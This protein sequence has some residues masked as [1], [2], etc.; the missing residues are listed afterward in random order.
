VGAC[1]LVSIAGAVS[2]AAI[3]AT[4]IQQAGIGSEEIRRPA[5]AFDAADT[6]YRTE[7]LPDHYAM[8]TPQGRVEV[9]ELS[10]RGLYAQDRF[11]YREAAYEA[12]AYSADDAAYAPEPSSTAEVDAP[13]VETAPVHV[14]VTA[15]PALALA[16]PATLTDVADGQ[17]RI[18]D[19]AATLAAR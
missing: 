4:P 6:G 13:A 5:A 10:T 14:A 1:A 17:P 19:V 11:G 8:I 12:P 9:A 3:N 15:Q 16:Q 18:I 7:S 2:G